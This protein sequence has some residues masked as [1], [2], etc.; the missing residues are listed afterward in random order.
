VVRIGRAR[1]RIGDVAVG[2][3]RQRVVGDQRRARR[4]A[5]AAGRVAVAG[6]GDP[7]DG[8]AVGVGQRARHRI[9]TAPLTGT[10]AEALCV[11]H[12]RAQVGVHHLDR[13]VDHRDA[14]ALAARH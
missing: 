10:V 14:H 5:G 6:D 9:R 11:D 12:V 4:D 1:Q 7:R 8:R 13:I 2:A 3:A